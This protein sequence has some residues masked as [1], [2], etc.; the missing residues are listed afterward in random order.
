MAKTLSQIPIETGLTIQ[1]WHVTQ[2]IDALTGVDAYDIT[3]SGSLTVT[4]SVYVKEFSTPFETNI[5]TYN[6]ESGELAYTASADIVVRNALTASYVN[7]NSGTGV[8]VNRVGSAY[9]VSSSNLVYKS[10]FNSFTSSYNTGSFL[11]SFTGNLLGTASALDLRAGTNVTINRVGTA[12]YISSSATSVGLEYFNAFTASYNTGS[13]TG[14]FTGSLLGTASYVNLVA[15]PNITINRVGSAF[16][17]SGSAGSGTVNTSSLLITASYASSGITFTKGDSTTFT[18]RVPGTL[19]TVTTSWLSPQYYQIPGGNYRIIVSSSDYHTQTKYLTL[20]TQSYAVGDV[21]EVGG[22]GPVPSGYF[23]R[24]AQ[25]RPSEQIVSGLYTTTVGTSGY[26]TIT[27]R[28]FL[29]LT[30]VDASTQ[31]IWVVSRYYGSELSTY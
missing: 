16:E 14:S 21:I 11:G 6:T 13:F 17:I 5:L 26:L 22:V 1:A 25:S 10:T 9:Y 24:I 2:S 15:G 12:Y 28:D 18:V 29:Q 19:E 20:P 31:N 4:G 3:I 30:C 27:H 23:I 7:L 8:V